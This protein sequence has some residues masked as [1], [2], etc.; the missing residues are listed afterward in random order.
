MKL[1]AEQISEI[2]RRPETAHVECKSAASGLPKTMWETYSSFANTEGGVI[3]LGVREQDHRFFLQGVPDADQL[4][5][6]I[7]DAVNNREVVSANILFERCVYVVPCDGKDVVVIDVPKADRH[8]KPVF[9]GT[10]FA[11]GSYRRNGEGDYHCPLESVKAML[12]DQVESAPDAVIVDG[13]RPSDLNAETLTR[14]RTLFSE[15]RPESAWKD[16]D[17]DEFLVRIGGARRDE[18]GVIRPTL[19]GLVCFGDFVTIA[20]HV[21]EYFVDYRER[22]ANEGRWTDRVCAQDGTWSG[23]IYD[24]FFRVYNRIVSDVRI[25][26][27]LEDDGVS[28]VGEAAVH[29]AVRELLANAL[30]HA[31]Y[32]G[33]R[34]IVIEK[35]RDIIV[36][37]NPGSFRANKSEAISGGVSDAR[38]KLIFNIFALVDIGERSGT[39]LS[40]L[41]ALWDRLKLQKPQIVE[42]YDPDRV[43]VKLSLV[44]S[45][46]TEL[47]QNCPKTAPRLPQRHSG[48]APKLPQRQHADMRVPLCEFPAATRQVYRALCA[49]VT[50]THR[51]MES[52]LGL[53]KTT[54]RTATATL[55]KHGY[56]RRVGATNGGH[57]ELVESTEGGR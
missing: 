16:F 6:Q 8:D 31:D 1:T 52:K 38:N 51:G 34:G 12:R 20:T 18:Q 41:F 44:N 37:Q 3:L 30:I 13:L 43:S 21:P 11:K 15:R 7:W 32:H 25:P 10:D 40:N 23:N 14:Y 28:R 24:F 27:A 35:L 46:E 22:L 26:F 50:L 5:K 49:D 9:A 33:R 17:D 29:A 4:V 55:V 2:V 56:L 53:S 54:I 36:Y 39:G 57:W 45:D 47:P 19:A 48:S 42:S